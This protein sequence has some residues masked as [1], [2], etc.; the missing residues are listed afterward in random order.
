M[1]PFLFIFFLFIIFYLFFFLGGGGWG[2][3]VK[4]LAYLN[5]RVFVTKHNLD[6]P[7]IKSYIRY[8]IFTIYDRENEE[9]LGGKKL[10]KTVLFSVKNLTENK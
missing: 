3:V 10:I 9:D 5:R 1:F 2:R 6:I 8:G 7:L 4:F